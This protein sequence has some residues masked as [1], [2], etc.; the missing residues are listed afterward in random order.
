MVFF[1]ASIEASTQ[2]NGSI[3]FSKKLFL[4]EILILFIS[5]SDLSIGPTSTTTRTTIAT[6]K[7]KVEERNWSAF[8][9]KPVKLQSFKYISVI[10]SP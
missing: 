7:T 10:F 1:Y 2:K 4:E 3:D 8:M 5:N 9:A 6:T